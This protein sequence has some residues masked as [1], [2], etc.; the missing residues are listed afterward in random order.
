MNHKLGPIFLAEG[1]SRM[2][3]ITFFYSCFICIGLL[4]G[5]NFVQGYI[6]T[7]VL[8]IPMSGQGNDHWKLS[9]CSGNHSD[10]T[11]WSIW[12]SL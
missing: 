12:N 9:F 7:V 5:M 10:C 1:I 4:A 2:N 3:V 11:H 6:L 8:D